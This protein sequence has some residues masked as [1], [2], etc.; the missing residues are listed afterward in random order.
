M[1]QQRRLQIQKQLQEIYGTIQLFEKDILVKFQQH[2][3]DYSAEMKILL[4][5]INTFVYEH[6][7]KT[8]DEFEYDKQILTLDATDHRL[9]QTFLSFKSNK[10][11]VRLNSIIFHTYLSHFL[12]L[13]SNR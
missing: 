5:Q 8:R 13:F 7:Q 4:L 6:L 12:Q 3:T 10:L 11:E 1:V 2:T 9:L